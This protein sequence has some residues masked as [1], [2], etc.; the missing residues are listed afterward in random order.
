MTHDS[1]WGSK[2]KPRKFWRSFV[3]SDLAQLHVGQQG[4]QVDRVLVAAERVVPEEVDVLPRDGGD[5][6]E[7]LQGLPVPGCLVAFEQPGE[8]HRVVGDRDIGKKSAALVAD[9]HVQVGP[10]AQ[11]LP[12]ADLRDGGPQLVV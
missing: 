12:P 6:L 10:A 5:G 1:N 2:P 4:L 8:Q 9:R 3:F 7:G 11:L